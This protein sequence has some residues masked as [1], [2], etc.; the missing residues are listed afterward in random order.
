MKRYG[1]VQ[2]LYYWVSDGDLDTLLVLQNYFSA[3]FPTV[4]TA[5]TGKITVYSPDGIRLGEKSFDVPKFGGA[6]F[7]VSSL[8]EDL[9]ISSEHDYGVLEVYI[10]IPEAIIGHIKDQKSFYFWDRFY[11]SYTNNKGQNCFVHGVDKTHIYRHGEAE[12]VYWTSAPENLSWAPEIPVDIED[13]DKFTVLM[14]NRS[15]QGPTLR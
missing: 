11:I 3:L 8:L 12:P 2:D 5:T 10:A 9:N 1:T 13:Y 7:R 14:I 4:E 15:A 6:R